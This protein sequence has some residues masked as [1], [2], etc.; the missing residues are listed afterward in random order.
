MDQKPHAARRR[1]IVVIGILIAAVAMTGEEIVAGEKALLAGAAVVD[2]T[3]NFPI[4]INGYMHDRQAVRA[5]DPLAV[6][7]LVLDDGTDRVALAICDSCMIPRAIFDEAK[8]RIAQKLDIRPS[9]ILCAA[10]HTHS[11]PTAGGVFQS[12][13]DRPYQRLL[14]ERIAA[15]IEAA[16][17]RRE[18]AEIGWG[19]EVNRSQVFNRRWRMKPG[20]IGKDPFGRLADQVMM[21]PPPGS[22]DLLEPAGP[23]DPEVWVLGVRSRAGRPMALLANYS[24]HYVG[25]VPADQVSA[26]Y[27]G[28]FCRLVPALVAGKEGDFVALLSNGTSGDCNNT[29]FRAPPPKGPAFT[30]NRIVG[31]AIAETARDAWRKMTWH[32][33]VELGAAVREIELGVRRPSRDEVESARATLKSAGPVL[34]TLPEIYARETVLLADYP[35]TVRVPL[36]VLAIGSLRICAI[37]CE[38]FAEIGLSLKGFDPAVPLFTIELANGYFGYLPTPAQHALGGYETWRARS[39]YLETGAS[40]KVTA[41]LQDLLRMSP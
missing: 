7:A 5:H 16:A 6:R 39:S 12:D 28:E 9:N 35:E 33:H 4:S 17:K 11:A 23:V 27:F 30:R 1:Q 19:K 26:D 22:P 24:M 2:I 34:R 32:A 13:P 31:Q 15:A 3:P 14:V 25:D 36:Q 37:P 8:S 20:A 29:N 18:P 41:A 21:N 38:V 40:E 10:T